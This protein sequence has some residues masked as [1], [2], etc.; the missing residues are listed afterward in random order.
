MGN[1]SINDHQKCKVAYS[2]FGLFVELDLFVF[3]SITFMQNKSL[4]TSGC[5]NIVTA[6]FFC[7][8]ISMKWH[9]M[10]IM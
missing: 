2:L 5:N 4:Q 6:Y 8:F 10:I 9:K 1:F 7:F 3:D